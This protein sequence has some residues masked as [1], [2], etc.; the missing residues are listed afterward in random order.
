MATVDLVPLNKGKK[1][2]IGEKSIAL[3]KH[4]HKIYAIQNNCPHQGAD[5]A[6]G[7]IKN[8]RVV[9][10]LHGWAYNLETGVFIG[11]E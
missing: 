6:D 4:G 5:L 10:P 11:N 2:I 1:I 8:D 7:H 9:C 3:F